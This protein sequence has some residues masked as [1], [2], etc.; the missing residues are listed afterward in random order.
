MRASTDLSRPVF[1]VPVH[2]GYVP[3]FKEQYKMSSQPFV[4]RRLAFTLSVLTLLFA[5]AAVAP[6]AQIMGDAIDSDPSQAIGNRNTARNVVQGTVSLPNN[7]RVDKRV[8]VRITGGAGQ[9]LFTWTDDN[10]NFIFRRLAGGTYFLSVDAGPEFHTANETVDIFTRSSGS[11]VVVPVVVQL[12]YRNDAAAEKTGTVNA[13]LADVPKPALKEYERAQKAAR[14]GDGKRAVESLKKAVELYPDFM[15]AYNDLGLAYFR[16][17][18]LEDAA[19]AL[20]KAIKLAP[21]NTTPMLNYGIVL[22]YQKQYPQAEEQLRAV[23][24]KREGAAKAHLF[25]GRSLIRQTKYA[26]AEQ[27]LRRAVELGGPEVNE[28]YRFLG[29]IYMETGDNKRAVEALEK[30]LTLEPN[31]KDAAAVREILAK[32]RTQISAT[33]NK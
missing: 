32:L 26:E 12:R 20:R 30:Y 1:D 2:E 3:G 18:Q 4:A 13:A 17:N 33:N 15:L 21:D 31:A 27:S 22:F 24:K 10:G 16:L 29:G 9:T 25:L 19:E 6:R 14:E 28:G 5:A 8:K 23:L 11:S 7:M